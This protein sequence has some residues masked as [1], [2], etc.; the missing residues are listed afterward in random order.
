MAKITEYPVVTEIQDDDVLLVDGENGTRGLSVSGFSEAVA[1]KIVE[2]TAITGLVADIKE[3][4]QDA[5]DDVIAS[6]PQDYTELTAEV[7]DLKSNLN[8]VEDVVF[9]KEV[10]TVN[11]FTGSYNP[12]SLETD[13]NM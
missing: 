9:A 11:N 4:I 5:G 10:V 1:D 13:T 12:T 8:D 3:E 7:D 2:S 6:I